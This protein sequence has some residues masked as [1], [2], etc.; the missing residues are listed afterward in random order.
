MG[1]LCG[2]GGHHTRMLSMYP[3]KN[4][5]P[6]APTAGLGPPT[7]TCVSPLL[8]TRSDSR[9][10][11][12]NEVPPSCGTPFKNMNA[13]VIATAGPLLVVEKIRPK[14][15]VNVIWCQKPKKCWW[16]GP[17]VLIVRRVW[18]VTL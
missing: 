2:H 13:W 10:K 16:S 8:M 14:R 4:E 6:E 7:Y 17:Q 5:K 11:L 15:T 1:K 18:I 3:V 12:R 9:L